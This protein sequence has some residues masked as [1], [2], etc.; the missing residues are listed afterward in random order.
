MLRLAYEEFKGVRMLMLSDIAKVVG[1]QLIGHGTGMRDVLCESVGSDS[2]NIAKNQLF[3]AIKGEHFDGNAYAAEA[4]KKG[5]AAALV[6][7]ANTQASPAVL[8]AD[9]RL[10]LGKL[11]QYWRATFPL[12]LVAVTGSNGKTTVKEMLAAILNVAILNISRLNQTIS[13]S[14]LATQGNLNNDIGMPM[15]LLKL[16]KQH[17]YA[18][19]EMG[20][21]HEGEI[22][23]LTNIAKPN[24]AVVNNAGIAHI[25]EVGSREGIARAKGEIFEGLA[26]DG[27]AVINADDAFADYWKSLNANRKIITFA[28]RA[29]A[30]VTASNEEV[31][32]VSK[33]KLITPAGSIHFKLHVLGTHNISNALA[34][35][36]CAHA[37]GISN[38]DIA[39]GLENFAA[40]KGRLQCKAGFNSASLIDDTYNANPDSMKAAIDVLASQSGKQVFVMG[41][42]AELGADAAQM[43]ADIGLYAKQKGI[44]QLFTFGELSQQASQAFGANSQH[45]TSLDTLVQC[46]K[47]AMKANTTVLVKG[48][49][50]M[51]MERVVKALSVDTIKEKDTS[52]KVVS[53]EL[54][55]EK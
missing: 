32:G 20:M 1:G 6:S 35:S 36:A 16:G 22:R 5:A 44:A 11:A 10:A 15:T 26:D 14:V 4:I 38:D 18:V 50:F 54:M 21:S 17:A 31:A 12:P 40:V 2:R 8:V 3:V 13:S 43:H 52:K 34:A 28:M 51:Q 42:M 7:D 29:K 24:V 33:I 48:S 49:R 30:D 45:F 37:L 23:Y 9:T 53:K 25:G 55:E 39:Q 46:L 19:I 47:K 27:I 41:D